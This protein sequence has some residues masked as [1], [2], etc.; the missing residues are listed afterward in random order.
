MRAPGVDGCELSARSRSSGCRIGSLLTPVRAR[1][2]RGR[3]P[4][5]LRG[6]PGGGAAAAGGGAFG[7]RGG[8]GWYS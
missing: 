6:G 5:T 7:S 3:P 1:W 4:P 2:P 8:G